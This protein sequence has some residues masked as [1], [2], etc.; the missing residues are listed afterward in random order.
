MK[1]NDLYLQLFSIKNE[2]VLWK[3]LLRDPQLHDLIKYNFSAI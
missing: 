2:L 3:L 1:N